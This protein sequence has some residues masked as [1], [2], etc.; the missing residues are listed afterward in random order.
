MTKRQQPVSVA[1]IIA[2]PLW[3]AMMLA[4]NVPLLTMFGLSFTNPTPTLMHYEQLAS[5]PAYLLVLMNTLKI[6]V[7][8]SLI[9]AVVGYP[10]AYWMYTLSGRW[11]LL[12]LTLVVVPFWISILVRTYAWI[13]LLGNAGIVNRTLISLGISD[14]SV[15]FLYNQF[16]VLIGT[17]NI[18][19]PFLVLPLFATMTR[20]DRRLMSA[21]ESLG[22][23]SSTT[24]TRVFFPL[25]FQSL[26]AGT[27]LVFML[28]LGFFVTPA[29]LGGGRVSMIANVLDILINQL[30]NWEEASAIASILFVVIMVFYF[31]YKWL[32]SRGDYA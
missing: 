14:S 1:A 30:P 25:T 21:A 7:L 11:Q 4:F 13:V 3:V 24:F 27:I 26:A 29:I 32:S 22:A 12:V 15:P 9:C 28:T 19:F 8:A 31:G 2:I 17:T 16:G 10:F 20:I 18:L 5:N 6:A 23:S